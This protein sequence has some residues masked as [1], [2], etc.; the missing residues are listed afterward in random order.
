MQLRTDRLGLLLDQLDSSI[1][2]SEARLR[3]LSDGE[4]FWE[5]LTSRRI[6]SLRRRGHAETPD[7]YGPGEW[8]LDFDRAPHQLEA[9]STVAW[10]LGHLSSMFAG[11]WEWTF[12][13]H[14]IDPAAVVDFAGT[15][16]SSLSQL[17]EL[18]RQWRDSLETLTD[19]QL[20]TVGFGQYPWGLDPQLPIIGI[21]WWINREYIHHTAEIALLRDLYTR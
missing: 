19:E 10:R 1:E 3:G 15:A 17:H 21:V 9:F 11:R 8:V 12:G 6:W 20:D 13:S 2:I 18:A 7:A 5:P 16:T 4:F 14:S